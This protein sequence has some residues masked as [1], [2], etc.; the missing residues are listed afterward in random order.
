M[1]KEVL[2]KGQEYVRVWR[3]GYRVLVLVFLSFLVFLRFSFLV[4]IPSYLLV[5]LLLSNLKILSSPRPPA[6]GGK[7]PWEFIHSGPRSYPFGSTKGTPPPGD[8][9]RSN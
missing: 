9:L 2:M 7:N 3:H 5:C 1:E 6:L 8:T 4:L